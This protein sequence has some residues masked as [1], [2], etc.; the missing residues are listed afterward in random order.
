MEFS[1]NIFSGRNPRNTEA[2]Q[3]SALLAPDWHGL[4]A[5]FAAAH[6]MRR[7]LQRAEAARPRRSGGFANWVAQ[8]A[9]ESFTSVNPNNSADG[10]D[11]ASITTGT[12][13]EAQSGDRG[14][15]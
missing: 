7:E 14:K 15:K 12:A 2:N 13:G 10:K 11:A 9:G 1:Q 8:H 6:A 5:R 3:G 4:Q